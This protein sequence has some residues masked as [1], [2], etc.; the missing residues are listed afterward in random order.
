MKL[1]Y[2]KKNEPYIPLGLCSSLNQKVIF[3]FLILFISSLT[4]TYAQNSSIT[5]FTLV[6]AETDEDI[7][8]L[9][10]GDELILSMLPT[11]YLNIRANVSEEKI[12]SVV[13]RFNDTNPFRIENFAPYAILGDTK[14]DYNGFIPP[15]GEH[16][17]TAT[18]YS[19]SG[20]K[21]EAGESLTITFSVS[22]GMVT[23]FT[24]VNADTDED[25]MNGH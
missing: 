23:D 5:G 14:G 22:I 24:L 4:L 25:I 12:G 11:S 18:P 17:I 1:K 15:A 21:G 9:Q 16:T 10:D 13:F 3:S 2:F 8:P 19:E 20:G 6:N 7:M